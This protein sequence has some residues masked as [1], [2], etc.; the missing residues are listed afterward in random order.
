M[1]VSIYIPTNN[2][3][4]GNINIPFSPHSLQHLLFF[5][6][7]MWPLWLWLVSGIPHCSFDLHSIIISDVEHLSMHLLTICMSS[8]GKSLFRSSAHF[9]IRFFDIALC[10]LFVYKICQK[11][12][13]WFLSKNKTHI[14]HFHQELYWTT[15][16]HFVPYH[17][18]FF[19]ELHNSIFPK[20]FLSFWAKN[21]SR[22]LLQSSRELKYFSIKRIL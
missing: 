16:H 22:C 17:L 11:K 20:L 5:D 18:L 7:L 10:E 12:L 2:I 14:I 15:F 6:L 21:C 19:R 9:L 4:G 13:L 8:F 3:R 1:A